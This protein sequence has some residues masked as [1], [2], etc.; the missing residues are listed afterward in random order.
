[1]AKIKILL[2]DDHEVVRRGLAL[3]L[4][5]EADLEVVGEAATGLEA[6]QQVQT[7]RP[8]FV[9]LDLRMPGMRG[10]QA[11]RTI[12]RVSPQTRV[13][14]VSGVDNAEE[15]VSALESNVDGYVLKDAPPS[16]LIHAIRVIAGGEAYLQP[17]VTKRLLRRM[18][19]AAD[20]RPAVVPPQL[21]PREL[22]IL[23]LVAANQSNKEIAIALTI[24][25]E[26]VRSH[27]KRILQKLEQPNR[28]QAALTAVRLGLID[29][30]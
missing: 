3:L 19:V 18:A 16:E 12:K 2:V 10:V 21:T 27:I 26:T 20:P 24:G 9:L 30:E 15:I 29:L 6:I 8:D 23:R 7:L 17:A 1:M 13:L 14:I 4:D 5:L 28:V 22:E 25:E 11:A